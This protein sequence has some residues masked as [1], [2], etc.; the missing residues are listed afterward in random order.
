MGPFPPSKGNL[1]IL[2][3]VDYVSKW[4]ESIA[5]PKNYA[6]TMVRFLQK[7]ILTRFEAPMAIMSDEGTHFYDKVF[8]APMAKYGVHHKKA[9]AYHTDELK[10]HLFLVHF[11]V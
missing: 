9:L 11:S 5:T 10:S 6:N 2:M 8:S 7:N 3:A 4:V 1:Y